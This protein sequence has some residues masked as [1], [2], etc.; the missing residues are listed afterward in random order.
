VREVVS[1]NG[2]PGTG[3]STMLRARL[4]AH[5]RAVVLD[6]SPDKVDAWRRA[7][8]TRVRDLPELSKAI[9]ASYRGGWRVVWTPPAER[10]G[11]ALHEVSRLLWK[12]QERERHPRPVALGV[13]EMAFCYSN[14]QSRRSDLSGFMA[15]VLQGRHLDIS[16]YGATQRPQDVAALFRDNAEQGYFFE[17][18]SDTGRGAV[19]AKIGRK[20]Q[21]EYLSLQPF[22]YLF[23]ERGKVAK[24]RSRKGA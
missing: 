2:S 19:L 13:D 16:I 14:A 20:Y 17:L 10:C 24:G 9:A 3:K 1:F 5:S 22:E 6:P 15:L 7:G 18:H 23:Y 8:Y 21:A 12:Y 11:E 4:R